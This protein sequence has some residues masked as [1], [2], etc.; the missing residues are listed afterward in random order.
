MHC[1]LRGAR[2]LTRRCPIPAF[3]TTKRCSISKSRHGLYE[4][5]AKACHN[6]PGV[7]QY[8]T[9]VPN[10]MYVSSGHAIAN[11]FP[12][13][14]SD[15]RQHKYASSDAQLHSQ[16]TLSSSAMFPPIS[17][18]L[19]IAIAIAV[20]A[21]MERHMHTR[22]ENTFSQCDTGNVKCCNSVA[23]VGFP[24]SVDTRAPRLCRHQGI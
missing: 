4:S 14:A 6:V 24:R 8:V 9:F 1:R 7:A 17:A 10:R 11:L 21:R 2:H 19:A 13:R 20:N 23:N 18:F 12:F 16:P 5:D 22:R 15:H 3:H